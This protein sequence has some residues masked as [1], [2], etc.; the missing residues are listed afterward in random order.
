MTLNG[1]HKLLPY[2]SAVDVQ[3]VLGGLN[4]I[5]DD[6][7]SARQVFYDIYSSKEKEADPASRTQVSS[8][9]AESQERHLPSSPPAAALLMSDPSTKASP[10]PSKSMSGDTTSSS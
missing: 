9:S 5:I 1:L 2:H 6:A 8:S 7:A 3:T 10:M 4:R